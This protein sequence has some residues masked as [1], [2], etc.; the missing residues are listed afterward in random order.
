MLAGEWAC[1]SQGNGVS[2]CR[3]FCFTTS[4]HKPQ[5][6]DAGCQAIALWVSREPEHGSRLMLRG[7]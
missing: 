6:V 1:A 7:S 5:P 2:S 3:K 4:Q